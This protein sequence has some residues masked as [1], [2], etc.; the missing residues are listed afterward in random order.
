MKT[1]DEKSG[2]ELPLDNHSSSESKEP[3]KWLPEFIKKII[4][5]L[6]RKSDNTNDPFSA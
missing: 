4:R 2:V 1:T 5:F 3:A 6:N